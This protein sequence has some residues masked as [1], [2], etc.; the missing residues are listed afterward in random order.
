MRCL[1]HEAGKQLHVF[2][3]EDRHSGVEVTGVLA[4]QQ[5]FMGPGVGCCLL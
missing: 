1:C 4:F 5:G 2:E 3:N